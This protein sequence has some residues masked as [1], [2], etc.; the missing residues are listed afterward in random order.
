MLWPSFLFLSLWVFLHLVLPSWD[1]RKDQRWMFAF[2]LPCL[3]GRPSTDFP[4]PLPAHKTGS[5]CCRETSQR[6][7]GKRGAKGERSYLIL[8]LFAPSFT[9]TVSW[10]VFLVPNS[11]PRWHYSIHTQPGG[12]TTGEALRDTVTQRGEGFISLSWQEGVGLLFV[13]CFLLFPKLGWEKRPRVYLWLI[14]GLGM[15]LQKPTDCLIR[16]REK[17]S[18]LNITK[19][20]ILPKVIW[21]C[22]AILFKILTEF[23]KMVSRSLAKIERQ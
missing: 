14:P 11:N 12:G 18:K 20:T 5:C 16:N 13:E 1:V 2:N 7:G 6:D 19:L 9:E 10:H 8:S 17:L 22:N 21:G 15:G 23:D 4:S 3:T